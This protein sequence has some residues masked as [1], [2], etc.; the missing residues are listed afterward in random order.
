MNTLRIAHPRIG[1]L[2]GNPEVGNSDPYQ[3]SGLPTSI[4]TLFM[5]C[6][7]PWMYPAVKFSVF[8]HFMLRKIPCSDC[9]TMFS[10]FDR[11]TEA[12]YKDKASEVVQVKVRAV[13]HL[14]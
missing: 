10:I 2:V 3:Y 4:I 13:P 12:G 8:Q 5:C 1:Y 7:G 11:A 9:L 6:P 14:R